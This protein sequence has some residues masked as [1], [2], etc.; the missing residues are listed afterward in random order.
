MRGLTPRRE[1][2]VLKGGT[3]LG[4]FFR[5]MPRGN[6]GNNAAPAQAPGELR[7]HQGRCANRSRVAPAARFCSNS[8]RGTAEARLHGL[9][10]LPALCLAISP[11]ACVGAAL[12]A[13]PAGIRSGLKEGSGQR[14]LVRTGRGIE[15][16]V[17]ASLPDFIRAPRFRQSLWQERSIAA[18]VRGP[19]ELRKHRGPGASAGG[20]RQTSR[21]TRPRRK[22]RG[23]SASAGE[24]RQRWQTRLRENRRA[25]QR[26]RRTKFTRWYPS[27]NLNGVSPSV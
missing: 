23:K 24:R 20:T 2:A 3:A 26:L 16:S 12:V 4:F 17:A 11:D 10:R 14:R 13:K 22:R 21:A 8:K 19:G 27:M 1:S 9:R 7:W 6:G 5:G 18:P 15:P 25:G